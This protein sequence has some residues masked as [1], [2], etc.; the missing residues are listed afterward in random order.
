MPN[1]TTQYL[2]HWSDHLILW[3]THKRHKQIAPHNNNDGLYLLEHYIV[4]S[5]KLRTSPPL[6]YLLHP[7]DH[8]GLRG[9]FLYRIFI[10]LLTI[11][12]LCKNKKKAF[13]CTRPILPFVSFVRGK[14]NLTITGICKAETIEMPIST[15]FLWSTK[16]NHLGDHHNVSL[17]LKLAIVG[18]KVSGPLPRPAMI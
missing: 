2:P 6:T 11:T 12:K 17:Q 15:F 14:K 5:L 10:S 3:S 7:H 4:T 9:V 13:I 8:C 16:A 1:K 18:P